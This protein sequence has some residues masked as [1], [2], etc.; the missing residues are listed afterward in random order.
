MGPIGH[1]AIGLAAKPVAPRISIW[2]LLA[3]TETLDLLCFGFVTLGVE[4][5]GTSQADLA[6]GIKIISPALILWSHGLLMSLVW[7]VI[8]AVITYLVY[9]DR[10][11]SAILGGLVLSHWVL[12]FVV[13]LPDL[14]LLFGSSPKVGLGLWSTGPGLVISAIL[15]IFLGAV[16]FAIYWRAR[17]SGR[18]LGKARRIPKM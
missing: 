16:G 13:H 7:S 8:A 9:H 1:F 12:D 15:E 10:R 18:S 5:L 11:T 17:Q 2:L 3:A 6:Q 14:P 4:V